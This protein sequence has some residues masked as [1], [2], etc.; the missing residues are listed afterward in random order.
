VF[1]A[2]VADAVVSASSADDAGLVFFDQAAC[3]PDAVKP[4]PPVSSI[5]MPQPASVPIRQ[6]PTNSLATGFKPTACTPGTPDT[7]PLRRYVP[8]QFSRPDSPGG[9]QTRK[10]LISGEHP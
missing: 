5:D 2:G 7:N 8:R 3:P 9:E 1:D 6:A 4:E 10:S